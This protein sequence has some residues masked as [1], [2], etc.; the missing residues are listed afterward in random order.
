MAS[1]LYGSQI[2]EYRK[3]CS[4]LFLSLLLFAF[5]YSYLCFRPLPLPFV[6]EYNTN[7]TFGAP[8]CTNRYKKKYKCRKLE[9]NK[10]AFDFQELQS[11]N[12]HKTIHQNITSRSIKQSSCGVLIKD[13]LLNIVSITRTI[14]CKKHVE[15]IIYCKS[16]KKFAPQPLLDKYPRR[17]NHS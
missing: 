17:F 2:Y 13:N 6:H 12:N 8:L 4:S 5:I 3:L 14:T 10:V 11:Y 1:V 16:Q 15:I 9:K 7:L